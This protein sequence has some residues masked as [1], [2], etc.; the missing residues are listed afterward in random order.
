MARIG[1]A[2]LI[3]RIGQAGG[4]GYLH[5]RR[6]GLRGS[7]IPRNQPYGQRRESICEQ[8]HRDSF[9][10][11]TAWAFTIVNV[12]QPKITAQFLRHKADRISDND[13]YANGVGPTE[14]VYQDVKRD[15]LNWYRKETE[16]LDA[17]KQR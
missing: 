2:D 10:S 3:E 5:R 13:A 12:R 15:C 8:S 16:R 7:H 11:Q 1:V 9:C 17:A 14:Q 6:D 4:G